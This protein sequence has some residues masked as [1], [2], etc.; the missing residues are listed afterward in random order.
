M[1]PPNPLDRLLLARKH[2]VEQWILPALSELCER[3]EQL[4]LEEARLMD[5]ED[6]VL[7]GSVRQAVRSSTLAVGGT[8]IGDCIRAWKI[9]E[10][11]SSVSDPDNLHGLQGDT[12]SPKPSPTV[13]P[14]HVNPKPTSTLD[15]LFTKKKG[16]K[17]RVV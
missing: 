3:P 15:G 9:G 16:K 8:G 10:P 1:K 7:V 17:V 5:F 11:W 6:V 14:I 12:P 2:A 13:G 4:S